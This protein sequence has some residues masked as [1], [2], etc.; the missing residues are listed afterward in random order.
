MKLL[1]YDTDTF[2]SSIVLS[3]VFSCSR[4]ES[5]IESP[6]FGKKSEKLCIGTDH[7]LN[8][9]LMRKNASGRRAKDQITFD[10]L[11]VVLNIRWFRQ[12]THINARLIAKQ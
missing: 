2:V 6:V 8:L 11:Y 7:L 4:G 1:A 10:I 5:A 12:M 3:E 9:S